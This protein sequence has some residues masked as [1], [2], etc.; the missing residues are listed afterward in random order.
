MGTAQQGTASPGAVGPLS[1]VRVLD[2]SSVVMGPLASQILGDLGAE[3]ISIEAEG[4]DT[5]R[6]MG[7]GPHRELSGVSLNL[8]RNKRNISLDLKDPAGR[9]VFLR[10]AAESDVLLTNLRPG[11]LGRLRLAYDDVRAVRPDIVFCQAH[12]WATGTGRED[13]PAFDDVI[14]AA[15]GITELEERVT[16]QRVLAPT[17]IADKL[18][19]VTMAYAVMAALFHRERTG[20]GQHIEVPMADVTA[21][22]VLVEHGAGA[23]PEPAFGPAGY[24]RILTSERRSQRTADGWINIL[25]F[26]TSHYAAIWSAGGRTDLVNDPRVATGKARIENAV[27]LYRDVAEVLLTRTT[28]FWLDYCTEHS[29]PSSAVRTVDDLVAEL[30]MAEHPVTGTYRHIPSPVRFSRTPASVRRPAPLIGEH[31]R[32]VLAE[33][34]MSAEE[35]DALEASGVLRQPSGTR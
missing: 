32:E 35:I 11:P 5:N 22:F 17:L 9:E 10:L 33:L 3:V 15:S 18:C 12:G 31:G 26:S 16:G 24:E 14:Q 7:P 6:V 8:L 21:A 28:A 29:I 13:A 27:E 1:G 34:G 4:G 19:G 25:P 2:L 23:I 30:P 20:E